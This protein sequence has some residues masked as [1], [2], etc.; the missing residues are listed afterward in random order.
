MNTR[1]C[2]LHA[3]TKGKRVC[4]LAL[5]AGAVAVSTLAGLWARAV[6]GDGASLLSSPGS[7]SRCLNGCSRQRAAC[8]LHL[9]SPRRRTIALPHQC[10]RCLL[11]PSRDTVSCGLM[12]K[13]L[14]WLTSISAPTKMGKQKHKR[15]G[16]MKKW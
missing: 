12:E 2:S 6:V 11:L 9:G 4:G 3:L 5:A 7:R 8:P 1:R 16:K 15:R 13:P 14:L 10:K